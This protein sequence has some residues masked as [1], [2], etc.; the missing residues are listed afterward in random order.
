MI[1]QSSPSKAA[2]APSSL[3]VGTRLGPY[4]VVEL[5]GAGGMGE[6]YRAH[7]TKLRRDVALKVLSASLAADPDWLARLAREAHLL[8][9]LNHSNIGHIYGMEEGDIGGVAGTGTVRAL[10][11]ELVEGPTLAD[12]VARG[13]LPQDEAI[14][15]ARQLARA[16]EYAHENGVIHRDL[17]PANIKLRADG[18]VKV[19]D[20]GIAK[21]LDTN[22]VDASANA[23]RSN[24]AT[25]TSH[26]TQLGVLLGTAA[27]MS[28]EQACGQP[29]D[30]RADI[31]AFGV[32]LYELFTG[33]RLFAGANTTEVLAAVLRA[34]IDWQQL[35]AT[36]TPIVRHVLQRCLERA[37]RQRLRDIGEARVLLEHEGTSDV[38]F[39]APRRQPLNRGLW[40]AL[41]LMFGVA[42]GLAGVLV[43]RNE[44]RTPEP[45]R[46]TIIAP[47]GVPIPRP[48][49]SPVLAVSRDGKQIALTSAGGIWLWTTTSGEARLLNDTHGAIAPFFSPDGREIAFFAADELRR[50][51][52]AG[53]PASTI[54]RAPAGSAGTWAA[55]D[56]ILYNRWL[57]PE[58]GLWSV[59]A[60]GGTPQLI[61]AAAT[62]TD[63]RAFPD[64]LP[65]GRHYVYLSGAYGVAVGERKLCVGSIDGGEPDCFAAGDSN[66]LYSGTGH[67]LFVRRGTLVALPFDAGSRRPSGEAISL[68]RGI[69][70]FGPTGVAA[71]A[72]SANGSLLVHA[73]ASEASRLVW[74]DRTGREV[75]QVGDPAR[76]GS[77]HLAPDAKRAI[78]EIWNSDR[79]GRDLH[80]LD[81][82]TG[83]PQ[84][85]TFDA[86]DAFAPA[87][88]PD[89]R[90]VAY[91]K[92]N[93]G[94]PD[95]AV[96]SIGGSGAS[97]ILLAAPGVQTPMHWSPDGRLLAYIDFAAERPIQRQ[98]WLLSVDGQRRRLREIPAESIDA[99]FSPDGRHIAYV[100]YE[101]GN[102][103]VYVAPVDGDAPGRRVSR[104]GGFLP[105]WRADGRELFFQ[106]PDG[107]MVSV[108][109]FADPVSP[110]LLFHLDDSASGDVDF[111]RTPRIADYDVAPDGQR[112]L[113][114]V[115]GPA[116]RND[117]LRVAIDWIKAQ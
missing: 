5:L 105:R 27:Y 67:L 36:T 54:V 108:E 116:D 107:I 85:L 46:F 4:E 52:I 22:S 19:L 8:A 111:P 31:W 78:V 14:A 61:A 23:E 81:L 96:M 70:W 60:R 9:S 7:D 66:V 115:R 3:S 37:P 15:I 76:Y 59:P 97:D 114:P 34:D 117:G 100:S 51:R 86:I 89:G 33:R 24:T 25:V 113:I 12:R 11:L 6:V 94:P 90:R 80:L 87:W 92:P 91:S 103:D 77:V 95:I 65:D 1:W 50:V 99:R 56:F 41:M 62:P 64:M 104:T 45:L 35:P 110:K 17:K 47:A 28:P 26:S 58:A 44:T 55:G 13:P 10:V 84:R 83:V 21:T 98:V 106:Q 29:L 32:V 109:P 40:I 43:L 73:L 71:F 42:A 57:G 88:S 53:G 93:P 39:A 16:L 69:R 20:F 2:V 101:S 18:T 82:A 102:A 112:F 63:I 75:A 79:E 72:V 68:A 74:I 48:A 49:V 38:A 30:K